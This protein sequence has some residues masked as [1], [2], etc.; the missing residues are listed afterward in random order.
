MSKTERHTLRRYSQIDME[1][2]RGMSLRK[3]LQGF[4][5][6]WRYNPA[7]WAEEDRMSLYNMSTKVTHF[8][9]FLSH[10][11]RS[12]GRWKILSLSLQCGWHYGLVCWLFAAAL[13]TTL[14]L[15]D[16]LPM[17]LTYR[18]NIMGFVNVCPLGF[19]I[20]TCS[21]L[22]MGLGL[23]ST[24]LWPDRCGHSTDTCFIDVASIH[25]VDKTLMERGVFGIAGFLSISSEMRILWSPPYL[26]RLW[27]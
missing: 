10:A 11:W 12:P 2:A 5:R 1:V 13:C 23:M 22:A 16:V 19:W 25:Q 3:S 8:Q 15:A 14:C 18:A 7:A 20:M 21:C 27:S 26:S 9:T 24:P 17:P 6:L 4:G